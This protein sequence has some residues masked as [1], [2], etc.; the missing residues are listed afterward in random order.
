[1]PSKLS[2]HLGWWW[3]AQSLFW[4]L[5][6]LLLI[7]ALTEFVFSFFCSIQLILLYLLDYAKQR[8]SEIVYWPDHYLSFILSARQSDIW[9]IDRNS[10]NIDI[11]QTMIESNG[12]ECTILANMSTTPLI[13]ETVMG[14][15]VMM[16]L[17]STM[18]YCLHHSTIS[19][20]IQYTI[21]QITQLSQATMSSS[22]LGGLRTLVPLIHRFSI[23]TNCKKIPLFL[24]GIEC[25]QD[26]F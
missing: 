6:C 8:E 21:E 23:N 22:T 13:W 16:V 20:R 7:S 18:P 15:G 11:S 24:T 4:Q 9:N 12:D 3:C 5:Y 17:F 25:A 14:V 19:S 10:A 1:M 26:H 2:F